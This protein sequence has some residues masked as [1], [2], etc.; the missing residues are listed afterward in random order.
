M[1][2]DSRAGTEKTS[3]GVYTP[4]TSPSLARPLARGIR[5]K[6]TSGELRKTTVD[7][8]PTLGNLETA[9]GDRIPIVWRTA[10]ERRR[11]IRVCVCVCLG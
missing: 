3:R 8:A 10:K 11:A 4:C 2:Y 7:F 5:A 6:K 9:N 1:Y